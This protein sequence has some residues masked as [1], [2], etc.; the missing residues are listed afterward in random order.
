MA[1]RCLLSARWVSVLGGLAALVWAA[2]A[3][4]A[5]GCAIHLLPDDAGPAWRAAVTEAA[6]R[7]GGREAAGDCRAVEVIVGTDGT[8]T[9]AFVTTDGRGAAR[10][11]E[12]PADLAPVLD[13]L[14]VTIALPGPPAAPP[15]SPV[16]PPETPSPARDSSPPPVPRP[17]WAA[18]GRMAGA[19]PS[20][21][22]K[23]PPVLHL[24]AGGGA[25]GRFTWLPVLYAAPAIALRASVQ[26]DAWELGL[27]ADTA[28]YAWPIDAS[29]PAG[30]RLTTFAAALTFGR[31]SLWAP[32]GLGYG[33]TIAVSTLDAQVGATASSAARSLAVALPR[34]GLYGRAIYPAEG[35]LRVVAELGIDALLGHLPDKG[36]EAHGMPD[37][38]RLGLA[39][40]GGVEAPFL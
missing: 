5:E 32:I 19:A 9:L 38:S 21:P 3:G 18:P 28:P 26:I 39:L 20:V 12:T 25:G 7:L 35:R 23:P 4:A 14:L 24:L 6:K 15:A 40:T 8:A 33:L 2:R 13:A 29:R 17:A 36:T 34:A 16:A 37:F 31:R 27:A 1:V 22:A 10:T 30:F 11:L